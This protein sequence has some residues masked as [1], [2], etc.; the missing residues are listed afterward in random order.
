MDVAMMWVEDGDSKTLTNEDKIKLAIAYYFNKWNKHPNCCHVNKSVTEK[1][2]E[3]DTLTGKT[4]II[5]D[6]SILPKHYWIGLDE[7][8]TFLIPIGDA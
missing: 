1:E 2:Y 7:K 4:R 6:H 3:L 8:D 5:P